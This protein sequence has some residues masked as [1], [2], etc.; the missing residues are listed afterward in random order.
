M[1][2]YTELLMHTN[3]LSAYLHLGMPPTVY[4]SN[5]ALASLC[6]SVILLVWKFNKKITMMEKALVGSFLL[7]YASILIQDKL[8]SESFWSMI[9][10]GNIFVTLFCKGTQILA[11]Y[12]N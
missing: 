7:A 3:T 10:Q 12:R 6:T 4:A 1:S 2:L 11:N 5:L 9:Q 8:V